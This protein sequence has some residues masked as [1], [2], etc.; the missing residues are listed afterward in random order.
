[1]TTLEIA[2]NTVWQAIPNKRLESLIRSIP[3]LLQA[4]IDADGGA[5]RY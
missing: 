2:L 1:M 5:T 3:Q 4:V